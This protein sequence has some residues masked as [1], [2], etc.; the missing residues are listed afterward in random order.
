METF[1]FICLK[2]KTKKLVNRSAHIIICDNCKTR[3][4]KTELPKDL[5]RFKNGQIFRLYPKIKMSK[6]ERLKLRRSKNETV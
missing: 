1:E 6:K 5:F 2:C 3:Y 4:S